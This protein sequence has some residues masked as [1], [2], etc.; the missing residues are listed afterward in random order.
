LGSPEKSAIKDLKLMLKEEAGGVGTF[1]FSPSAFVQ[2]QPL[3]FAHFAIARR[4]EDQDHAQRS[5]DG[6]HE[7]EGGEDL[8]HPSNRYSFLHCL[9]Y[10]AP[11]SL[12][13]FQ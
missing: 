11:F 3:S 5:R 13:F 9:A 8:V 7:K 6:A 12:P 4:D 1:Y 2:A 10:T